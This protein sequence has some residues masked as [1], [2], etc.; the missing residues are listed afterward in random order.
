MR[1]NI[2]LLGLQMTLIFVIV[3]L[4]PCFQSKCDNKKNICEK[5]LENQVLNFVEKKDTEIKVCFDSKFTIL[6]QTV[7]KTYK[8]ITMLTESSPK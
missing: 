1:V 6:H 3:G 2:I 8:N 7:I 5:K 4:P